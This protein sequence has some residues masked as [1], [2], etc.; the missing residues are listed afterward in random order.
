MFVDEQ[1]GLIDIGYSRKMITP[2]RAN[3]TFLCFLGILI[4]CCIFEIMLITGR[5][6]FQRTVVIL[7]QYIQVAVRQISAV[8]IR[9]AHQCINT[10]QSISESGFSTE[11]ILCFHI[12]FRR[13]VQ[14]V[15]T[16]GQC[17][18]ERKNDRFI[19]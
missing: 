3:A 5:S 1:H 13:N 2:N 7:S 6:C 15:V 19:Y 4:F 10:Y 12:R 16:A 9:T 18:K 17:H 8:T 11:Q 14:P